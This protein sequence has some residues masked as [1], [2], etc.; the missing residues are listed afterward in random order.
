MFETMFMQSREEKL[1]LDL[2]FFYLFIFLM[3]N[4]N[5]SS[6]HY[7]DNV[8]HISPNQPSVH[9]FNHTFF[10]ETPLNIYAKDT[11]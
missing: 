4:L 6:Y 3:G 5:G 8:L 1:Y 10:E 2:G 9:T 11:I 7:Y